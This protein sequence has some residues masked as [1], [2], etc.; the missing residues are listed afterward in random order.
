V[1]GFERQ[2]HGLECLKNTLGEPD[3]SGRRRPVPIEGSEFIIPADSV[4]A[5]IGQNVDRSF[6]AG[7]GALDFTKQGN[8]KANAD[9]LETSVKGVFAGGDV[10]TGPST[11]IEAIAQGRRQPLPW[12][13][14]SRRGLR[15][16]H[17]KGEGGER[18]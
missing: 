4:I 3:S 13:L 11:V 8:V 6:A 14:S 9:T 10:V 16:A 18:P 7:L 5:A 12:P 15:A 17:H 1:I 2:A